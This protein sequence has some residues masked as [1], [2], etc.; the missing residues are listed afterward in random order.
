V[1]LDLS[2]RTISEAPAWKKSQE[3]GRP[4]SLSVRGLP[5]LVRRSIQVPDKHNQT[6]P[7]ED[8]RTSVRFRGET[9]SEATTSY[10]G[11][12]QTTQLGPAER[13]LKRELRGANEA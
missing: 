7:A 6:K 4:Y 12:G 5:Y 3:A 10:R 13:S 8:Q 2:G 11:R 1:S 9:S